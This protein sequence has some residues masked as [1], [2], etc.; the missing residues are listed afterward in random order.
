[1]RTLAMLCVATA[2]ALPG[3]AAA[4]DYRSVAEATV[5]YDTPSAQGKKLFVVT[6]GTPLEVVVGLDQWVKVRDS[7]GTIA[8]IAR[9]ALS[10][11]HTVIVTAPTAD[12][13]QQADA[14]APL[15]F[16]AAHDV[17]LEMLDKNAAGWVKVRHRDGSTG[18]VR[19]T[20]VWGE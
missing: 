9:K 17:V 1:M 6:K 3:V 4:L 12:V 18:Y 16:Q 11:Q 8:W 15:A 13:R 2:L 14:A 10:A 20:D 5:L 19:A 7:A